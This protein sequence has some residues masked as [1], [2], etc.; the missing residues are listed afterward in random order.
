MGRLDPRLINGSD[1]C[2]IYA[3]TA[4]VFFISTVDV[5]NARIVRSDPDDFGDLRTIVK[6]RDFTT[7][8]NSLGGGNTVKAVPK[9][10]RP[11]IFTISYL[12]E[13]EEEH[14]EGQVLL[15]S[16]TLELSAD[17]SLRAAAIR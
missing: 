10:F 13:A 5:E 17:Q 9:N 16:S 11:N 4:V 7:A 2:P 15:M 1:I 3:N 6:Q 8:N 14:Q 12:V